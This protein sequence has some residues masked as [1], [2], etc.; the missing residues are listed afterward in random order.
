MNEWINTWYNAMFKV[1]SKN[2]FVK[3][4]KMYKNVLN[5]KN[6]LVNRRPWVK[7]TSTYMLNE[8]GMFYITEDR[9]LKKIFLTTAYFCLDT[10]K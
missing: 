4:T 10:M 8:N 6:Y 5:Q 1:G 2:I 7:V 3:S 9:K